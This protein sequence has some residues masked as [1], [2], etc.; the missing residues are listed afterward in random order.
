MRKNQ[1]KSSLK[2]V[3]NGIP[4]KVFLFILVGL[5]IPA[6][7]FSQSLSHPCIW[8]NSAEKEEILNK[9]GRVW[10]AES[11]NNQLHNRVDASKISHKNN[12]A[13]FL[14]S[15]PAI[16]NSSTR[17]AHNDKVTLA[18][19]SATLYF[20]TGDEDYAQLSADILS[21]YTEAISGM[22]SLNVS[23]YNNIW[24]EARNDFSKLAM[25]YDL[26]F[27]FIKK[28]GGITVFNKTTGVNEIFNNENAQIAMEFMAI[29]T[30]NN[31]AALHSNHSLLSGRGALF[32]ILMIEDDATRERLLNHFMN[33]PRNTRYDPF[34]WTL[35][36]FSEDNIWPESFDYSVFPSEMALEEMEVIDRIKP[37]WNIIENNIR[38][39]NG[40]FSFENQIYPNKLASMNYGDNDRQFVVPD[41]L[42][43]RVLAIASRKGLTD[44][45]QKAGERLKLKYSTK[46]YLP[47]INTESVEWNDLL[48]L[49]W[50][51][52]FSD[53]TANPI[54]YYTVFP[55]THA[56]IAVQRNINGTNEKN[57]GLMAYTG[58]ANFVH[59]HLQGID[60]ELYGAGY[61]LGAVG[62]LL[63]QRSADVFMNY[64]RIFAG[65]NTVIVNGT[66]KGDPGGWGTSG[67]HYQNTVELVASEPEVYKTPVS[68]NFS[69]TTQLL[70]DKVN[71]CLQQRTLSIIRTSPT[72]GYYF[73]MF[74]SKA[75]GENMFHDYI[76]HNIGEEVKI[77]DT[78]KQSVP[79]SASTKYNTYSLVN[80]IKFPGWHYFENVKSSADTSEEMKVRFKAAHT[81]PA[82]YTHVSIP[83]GTNRE[84]SSAMG[85]QTLHGEAGYTQ[86][87]NRKTPILAIRKNGEAW[88]S[89]FI[90]AFELTNNANSNIKSIAEIKNHEKVVGA[91]I[92]SEIDGITI[93]D[94]VICQ[95]SNAE[96]LN[97]PE[98]GISFTGRFAIIR[99]EVKVG[100]LIE[101][102]YIGEGTSLSY[103][104][105][106]LEA[107]AENKGIKTYDIAFDPNDSDFDG[108]VNNKD[109]CPTTYN[110]DQ[111]DLD[112]DGIGDVCDDDMDGD[113]FLNE[114][115]HCPKTFS[116]Q[117]VDIDGDGIDDACDE[118]PEDFDT[119]GITDNLDNCL[120][121][122]NAGQE[123]FNSNG[124]G[125]ACDPELSLL[126][127]ET[128]QASGT[129]HCPDGVT[130]IKVEC[131]GA[132][133][134]GGT[135]RS[136]QNVNANHGGGGAGGAYARLNEFT[137]TPGNDYNL[138]VGKCPFIIKSS[139]KIDGEGTWFNS[140][141]T[142]F[143]EG[144]EPAY[145]VSPETWAAGGKGSKENSIGEV[146][147]KG[148][149]GLTP[150]AG[151]E[152]NAGGGGGSA[153]HSSDGNNAVSW[154]S[155]AA[156][157]G[158]CKGGAAN[159]N[160]TTNTADYPATPEFGSG[161]GGSYA[162]IGAST[163][164]ANGSGGPGKI[165]ISYSINP[166][167]ISFYLSLNS[168]NY[169]QNE[170]PSASQ[171]FYLTG[172]NLLK[173]GG[174]INI[175]GS[176]NFE[177]SLDNE[178]FE[179][180]V[181][182]VCTSSEFES[183][184]V[185][186]R[187]KEGLNV[188][189]FTNE[190]ISVKMNGNEYIRISCS[191]TV[192]QVSGVFKNKVNDFKVFPNPATDYVTIEL[193]N[194]ESNLRIF[195]SSG[196]KVY[197]IFGVRNKITIPTS[198]LG[199]SGLYTINVNTRTRKVLIMPLKF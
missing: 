163:P 21:Y 101:T 52:D 109:N 162:Q 94:W 195:N 106:S 60:M 50:D 185:Y 172:S 134:A 146:T 37:E 5:L 33:N 34:T 138:Q 117:Q 39:L 197:E 77:S 171:P 90:A 18:V 180:S 22:D 83:A 194:H 75:A 62:G 68:E 164:R 28:E 107:V 158:G 110:P 59:C 87:G 112:N 40:V 2:Y 27:P 24:Y 157:P 69:F 70:D 115:D 82:T 29:M 100:K 103:K 57:D 141:T 38:I 166:I 188:G 145:N 135:A 186:V 73:D 76:Y 184:P 120:T 170:G 128:I 132:G 152:N 96:V 143:A 19:E 154:N 97:I 126:Q 155:V 161:G 187:L 47:T 179:A 104:A 169:T 78:N 189:T 182:L 178:L 177:V 17:S 89:P 30:L 23:I 26:I 36:H 1:T 144:G 81:T 16:G 123:D 196:V 148:G 129:W 168:L 173:N 156:V 102:L 113:G 149:D 150:S 64:Y 130:K 174:E 140:P 167:I 191:G 92:V 6:K 131:W 31:C 137:V 133:G 165:V 147:F 65:H 86:Y 122:S 85:P 118:Y 159:N 199:E 32:P 88:D 80:G 11:L 192:D 72:S 93:T 63:A 53:Y 61:V 121:T 58:G 44:I 14:S 67:V 198:Q 9:I 4:Q 105:N 41:N 13:G 139:K 136:V 98:E 66:S 108:I 74:R 43:K 10:W 175:Y 49:F 119:D 56:G 124:I 183:T 95:E 181:T 12:R 176:A 125:D 91:K 151:S 190:N 55:V 127:S 193:G 111:S 46:T 15:M 160:G 45:A 25:T 3:K 20:L 54:D 35:S 153:G 79:L 42:Y 48:Q 71:N 84:Y 142:V 8:A 116:V 51:K 99:Q 114:I 7:G